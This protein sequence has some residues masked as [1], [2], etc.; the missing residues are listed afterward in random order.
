MAL[1]QFDDLL[2]RFMAQL[3]LS[4]KNVVRDFGI[5]PRVT[6]RSHILQQPPVPP[7]RFP[8]GKLNRGLR[9]K[10]GAMRQ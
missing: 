5:S 4:V 6:Q 2:V 8:V 1:E 3:A 7:L 9:R 10:V